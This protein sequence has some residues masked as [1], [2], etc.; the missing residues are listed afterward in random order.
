MKKTV[1]TVLWTIA[2][3]IVGLVIFFVY[4]MAIDPLRTHA[5]L[6]ARLFV[7]GVP[8]LVWLLGLWGVLPGTRRSKEVAHT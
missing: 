4:I 5:S 1:S 2:S 6:V 7:L 3:Q 8:A